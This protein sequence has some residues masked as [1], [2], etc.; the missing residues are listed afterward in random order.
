MHKENFLSYPLKLD[1]GAQ[2]LWKSSNRKGPLRTG[3]MA[4]RAKVLHARSDQN[5]HDRRT[6]QIKTNVCNKR[7]KTHS[8]VLSSNPLSPLS[9]RKRGQ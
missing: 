1:R 6:D 8:E 4:Q 3:E 7:G 2:F 5:T 9:S